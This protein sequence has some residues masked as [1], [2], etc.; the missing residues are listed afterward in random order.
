MECLLSEGV[1]FESQRGLS[2]EIEVCRWHLGNSEI[3]TTPVRGLNSCA[4]VS[5][6]TIMQK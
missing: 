1:W 6:R 4:N 5:A 2:W 3:D